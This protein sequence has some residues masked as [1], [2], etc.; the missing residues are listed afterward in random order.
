MDR[1]HAAKARKRP[2]S[3]LLYIICGFFMSIIHEKP[4]HIKERGLN[5]GNRE[6]K[7]YWST[8]AA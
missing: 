2:Q 5:H 3:M 4:Q 8:G 6:Q 1:T 7:N